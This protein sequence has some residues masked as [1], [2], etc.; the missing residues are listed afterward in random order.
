MKLAVTP[1]GR[2]T[3]SP[4]LKAQQA[5]RTGELV[6]RESRHVIR[7]PDAI[8]SFSGQTPAT[9]DDYPAENAGRCSLSG[10]YTLSSAA[11]TPTLERCPPAWSP[12]SSIALARVIGPS[13][14]RNA[15]LESVA[16]IS[17]VLAA[18]AVAVA[19]AP[20]P[21]GSDQALDAIKDCLVRSSVGLDD[22]ISDASTIALAVGASCE[23][24]IRDWYTG[25]LSRRGV[26]PGPDD[27][28]ELSRRMALIT[29]LQLRKA[30]AADA[31]STAK[32]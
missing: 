32:K 30:K 22:G 26:T 1:V 10:R 28:R 14:T 7:P 15:V 29:V 4:T 8:H 9:G 31:T 3:R 6:D 12:R 16:L 24:G 13:L 2:E 19:V 23:E 17:I 20:A 11:C 25:N 5:L 18:A 27:A 21:E